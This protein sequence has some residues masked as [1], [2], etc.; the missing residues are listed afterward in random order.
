M[1]GRLKL[2]LGFAAVIIGAGYYAFAVYWPAH[3]LVTHQY[4]PTRFVADTPEV[5]RLLSM[6][7]DVIAKGN[8]QENLPERNAI[9][10]RVLIQPTVEFPP[11][12]YAR[13]LERSSAI[14]SKGLYS[15]P[16][17]LKVEAT[18][19]PAKGKIGWACLGDNIAYSVAYP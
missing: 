3:V 1:N 2:I 11:H 4:E 9:F 18:T 19:G 10:D 17:F 15:N 7:E 5:R 6:E 16:I 8:Y 12:S 14:C 13:L